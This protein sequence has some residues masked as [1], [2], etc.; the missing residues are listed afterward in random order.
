MSG[1]G[2]QR[3]GLCLVI[4]APSGTGK[5]SLTRALLAEEPG[6]ALSISATTRTPRPGEIDGKHYLFRNT[7]EFEALRDSGGL[8]E[9]AHVFGRETL[10]GTPRAPVEAALAAGQDMIF[11]IDWQGYRQMR[12]ALPQDVVGVFLL[13]P[14]MPALA[15]RLQLRG[16]DSPEEIARR[17][18]VAQSE[19]EHYTEFDYALIN[20]DFDEAVKDVRAILRAARLATFRQTGLHAFTR[21]AAV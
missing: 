15:V 16:Q 4:A 6:L 5:S 3:R 9:W 2:L 8:L 14:S 11:T 13:P 21:M 19:L 18:A 12:D 17:M 20:E 1:S 7:A 10:Y